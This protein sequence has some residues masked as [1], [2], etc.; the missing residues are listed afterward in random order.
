M[1]DIVKVSVCMITYK[2]E[3][4]ISQAIL[5]VLSQITDFGI[6]LIIADDASPDHTEELV[7]GLIDFSSNGNSIRYFRHKKN[8]GMRLNFIWALKKCRGEYI[9][10]CEGDDY[11]TDP[12]KLQKQINFMDANPS[13]AGCFH[14]AVTV[15]DKGNVLKANHFESPKEIYD[16]FDSLTKYGS[17]YATCTLMFRSKVLGELPKWFARSACDYTLGFLIS[18][19]GHIAHVKM[20]MGAY[21]IHK[22]GVWQ[23]QDPIKNMEVTL[24]RHMILHSDK[25]IR[26]HYGVFLRKSINRLSLRI[27]TL[28]RA[29]NKWRGHLK[30]SWYHFIY[31]D[32]RNLLAY[33]SLAS[34]FFYPIKDYF[35]RLW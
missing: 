1:Q 5:G 35:S 32:M 34:A 15:D 14:D 25:M 9:S 19:F 26:K 30:Y 22:G 28:Y 33:K 31:S 7:R 24:H 6:E 29:E 10:L 23:G 27:L 4:F 16:Q 21:R 8:I 12:Y 18:G 17:A 13:V 3:A 11:W 2:H 20:N